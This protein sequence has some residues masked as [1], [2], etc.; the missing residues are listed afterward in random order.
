MTV[1]TFNL[2]KRIYIYSGAGLLALIPLFVISVIS[3][4]SGLWWA[5]YANFSVFLM[6]I[7]CFVARNTAGKIMRMADKSGYDAY[8]EFLSPSV[9]PPSKGNPVSQPRVTGYSGPQSSS[10]SDDD[11]SYDDHHHNYNDYE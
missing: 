8:M 1:R 7:M 3:D 10:Y 2:L 6:F 9:P 4:F 5:G 11:N